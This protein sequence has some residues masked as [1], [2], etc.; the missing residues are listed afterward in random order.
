MDGFICMGTGS[1]PEYM[2]QI[3]RLVLELE[4]SQH[5]ERYRSTLM[6]LL[7]F[8]TYN[9]GIPKTTIVNGEVRKRTNKDWVSRDPK[10]G[11]ALQHPS[12]YTGRQKYRQDTEECAGSVRVR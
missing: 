11:D 3:G 9:R 2:L 12:L 10:R 8:G 1:M 7:A 5:G 4:K 6:E